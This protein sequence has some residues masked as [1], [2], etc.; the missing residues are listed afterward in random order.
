M[1]FVITIVTV[2]IIVTFVI[3]VEPVIV[4]VLVI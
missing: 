1:F 4:I 2:D 3:T